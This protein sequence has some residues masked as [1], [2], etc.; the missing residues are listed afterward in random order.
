[1]ADRIGVKWVKR[2]KLSKC[3][4]FF[5]NISLQQCSHCVSDLGAA[6]LSPFGLNYWRFGK[7]GC[8]QRL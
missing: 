4:R 7:K 6:S 5:V 2:R 8:S 3:G 1:M